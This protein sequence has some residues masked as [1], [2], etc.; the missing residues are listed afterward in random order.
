MAS[1]E[2]FFILE[3]PVVS[4]RQHL[5]GNLCLY[6]H[7]VLFFAVVETSVAKMTAVHST[8]YQLDYTLN[9]YSAVVNEFSTS[10]Y[11]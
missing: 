7:I 4:D 11:S 8:Y 6:S 1:G 3:L 10:L 5:P 9:N 2:P